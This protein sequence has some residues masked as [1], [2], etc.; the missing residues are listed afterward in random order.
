MNENDLES[1]DFA[2]RPGQLTGVSRLSQQVLSSCEVAS[3]AFSGIRTT[4]REEGARCKG[5]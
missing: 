4:V 1:D 2:S 3:T 5:T